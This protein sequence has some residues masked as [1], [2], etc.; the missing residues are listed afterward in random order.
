MGGVRV[1]TDGVH[2]DEANG[3]RAPQQHSSGRT[4]A[5]RAGY[6]LEPSHA[7]AVCCAGAMGGGSAASFRCRRI[8]MMTLL[9]IMAAMM[10]SRP[11]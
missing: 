11:C 6:G 3:P 5:L 8:F 4:S 9:S 10:R 1:T 2:T 7:N